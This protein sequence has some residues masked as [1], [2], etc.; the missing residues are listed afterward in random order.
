MEGKLKSEEILQSGWLG[1][2]ISRYPNFPAKK[3]FA[4]DY[5]LMFS[6]LHRAQEAGD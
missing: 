4:K 2:M 5:D 3:L 6:D 1:Y